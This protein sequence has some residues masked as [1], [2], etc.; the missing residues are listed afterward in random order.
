MVPTN[1]ILLLAQAPAPTAGEQL[2][3]TLTMVGLILVVFYFIFWRPQMKRDREQ[4][5]YLNALKSGDEVVTMGGI[6]GTV[7][8]VDN[9][10]LTIEVSKGTKIRVLKSAIRG[11]ASSIAGTGPTLEKE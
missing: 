10:I 1:L 6:L 9:N 8:A 2:I 3:S 11:D 4:K 5:S 7:R